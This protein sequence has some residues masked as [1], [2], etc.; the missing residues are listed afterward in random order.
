[1]MCL[2]H[3]PDMLTKGNK[4]LSQIKNEYMLKMTIQETRLLL[5]E[6][7]CRRFSQ[8]DQQFIKVRLDKMVAI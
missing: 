4:Q 5:E 2:H 1:M 7:M 6:D 3:T 8:E